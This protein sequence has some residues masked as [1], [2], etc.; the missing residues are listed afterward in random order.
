LNPVFTL[1]SR[2]EMTWFDRKGE[3]PQEGFLAFADI[4]YKPPLKPWSG[5]LRM[6]YFETGGYDSRIYAFEN[7]VSY[8]YSIPASY[9]KG[10][11]YYINVNYDVNKKMT[12]WIK[13][14]QTLYNGKNLIGSGLDEIKGSRK[15]EIRLQLLYKF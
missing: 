13:W 10:L 6:Q 4:I 5:N 14:S 9:E 15:S 8:T 7:D 11:R 1:R 3:E 2:V 12:A